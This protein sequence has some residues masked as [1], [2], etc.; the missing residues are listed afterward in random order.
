MKRLLILFIMFGFFNK[1]SA[2]NNQLAYDY[3]FNSI[4]GEKIKLD[5]YKDKVIVVV[6]VASRCGYT[7]Q[8]NDLQKLWSEYKMKNLVV[9]GIP[10]NNFKQEP[11]SNKEI[12]DFCETNFGISFPMTEKIDVIGNK[13][14]PFYKWA[15]E[16]YGIGAIPKWNFHKIVIGKNGKVIDTFASFTK[17]TSKKFLNLIEKEIKS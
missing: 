8:Y 10:T 5:D 4:D 14:H 13:A 7:P 2:D 16:T 15:K 3:Q 12:K 9:I 17:P 6:N 11:G 1:L